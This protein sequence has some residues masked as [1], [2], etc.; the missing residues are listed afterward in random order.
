MMTIIVI[1]TI[2][3]LIIIKTIIQAMNNK[4]NAAMVKKY[5]PRILSQFFTE[6]N[7]ITIYPNL[8]L[9]DLNVLN[10]SRQIYSKLI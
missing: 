2:N 5:I 4:I 1:I 8:H 3:L 6:C 7:R 9:C 10:T